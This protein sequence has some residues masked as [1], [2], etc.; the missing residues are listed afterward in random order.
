MIKVMIIG[1]HG[2]M[3]QLLTDRLLAET[4][5]ELVLFLRQAQRLEKYANNERVQLVDGDVLNTEQVASAM[6][7]VDIVYSNLGGVN[8]D[9]QIKGVIDAM[10]QTKK[11]ER[12]IY[13]SSLGAHHEVSGKFGE[14]NE[15][16]IKAYLPGFRKAAKLVAES[17]LKYTE[18][19]PAWLT[20]ND[21]IS[22]ETTQVYEPFKGTEVSRRSVADFAFQVVTNPQ[23][24]LNK[25]V[26]LNKPN[27]DGDKPNWV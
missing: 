25:S 27:S 22:Y 24:Q 12:F 17:G 26:G 19:R 1:A 3:A 23:T 8:L 15:Q 18:I 4:D 2:K 11:L 14:W 16:A 13:I 20:D 10:K 9:T 21:E 6:Q 7:S 5:D